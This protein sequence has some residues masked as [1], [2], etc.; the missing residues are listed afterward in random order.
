MPR[1]KVVLQWVSTYLPT[2]RGAIDDRALLSVRAISHGWARHDDGRRQFSW[3]HCSV[4]L[5]RAASWVNNA[6]WCAEESLPP[7]DWLL[8]LLLLGTTTAWRWSC[9]TAAKFR[10]VEIC[11]PLRGIWWSLIGR[12]FAWFDAQTSPTGI[13]WLTIWSGRKMVWQHREVSGFGLIYGNFHGI[14]LLENGN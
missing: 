2:S 8:L 3:K 14:N 5:T 12:W 10:S 1:G 11:S 4:S 9:P 7:I 6:D 13:M